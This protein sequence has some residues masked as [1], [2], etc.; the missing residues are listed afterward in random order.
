MFSYVVYRIYETVFFFKVFIVFVII[1]EL[2][3]RF[4]QEMHNRTLEFVFEKY[5]ADTSSKIAA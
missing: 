1:V 4:I 5:G 3:S 2:S